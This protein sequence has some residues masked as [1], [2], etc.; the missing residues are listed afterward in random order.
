MKPASKL[1]WVKGERNGVTVQS[2]ETKELIIARHSIDVSFAGGYSCILYNLKFEFKEG[3]LRYSINDIILSH[4]TAVSGMTTETLEEFIV[5]K[6]EKK[7]LRYLEEVN[8]EL[9]KIRKSLIDRFK[10][11]IKNKKK[12]DDW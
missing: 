4:A 6:R 8:M 9:N 2:P 5:G 12:N 1:I 3:K 7:K 11:A 10:S